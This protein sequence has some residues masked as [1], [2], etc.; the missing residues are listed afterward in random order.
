[1]KMLDWRLK[2]EDAR[3]VYKSKQTKLV[4]ILKLAS[5]VH[6]HYNRKDGVKTYTLR[7]MLEPTHNAWT[8]AVK[9]SQIETMMIIRMSE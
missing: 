1:M 7:K 8:S 4:I 3:S 5:S 9:L 6:T 2:T